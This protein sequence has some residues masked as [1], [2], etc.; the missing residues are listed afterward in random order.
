MGIG[1]LRRAES[2]GLLGGRGEGETA[3]STGRLTRRFSSSAVRIDVA[4][5]LEKA[6][7]RVEVVEHVAQS[8]W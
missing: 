6:V 8:R 4:E 3:V 1:I 7:R 2:R 5:R